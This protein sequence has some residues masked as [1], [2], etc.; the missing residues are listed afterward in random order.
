[1][2]KYNDIIFFL[3]K[4]EEDR[5][6]KGIELI[7]SENYVSNNVIKSIGSILTNKYAEGYPNK[8]YYGGC[9][10]IDKIEEKTIKRAKKL[11]KASFA[12]VQPH[13]GSQANQAVYLACL[14]PGDKILGFNLSHGGHLS[15]GSKVNFSGII[16]NSIF[17]GVKKS[18]NLIDYDQVIDIAKKEKPKLII[19]GAS[20]YSRD[21]DYKIFRQAADLNGSILLADISHTAGLIAKN[22]L[23]N[24][25]PYCH[26]I[27]TTTHKTLRGPRGGLILVGEDFFIKK[28]KIS[29]L[30]NKAVFP[31]IQGGPFENIIA[32]KA[33]AFKEAL[34]KKYEKYAKNIIINSKEL[35]KH[36]KKKG[37]NIIS[38]GTDNHCFILNLKNKKISGK[39]AEELLEKYNITCNKNLIPYDN[40]SPFITSGIRIGTPAITTRGLKKKNMKQ[41]VNWIDIILE[42]RNNINICNKIKKEIKNF[43]YSYPLFKE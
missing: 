23:N 38:N 1:M 14:N 29:F 36:F 27:T 13:S 17:Y 33:I 8:R 24:P 6:K 41:I 37:Y 12:N 9:N 19:C 28:K 16:Y 39:E 35:S 40:K 10:L 3:I 18:N 34:N 7:A 43:M 20:S 11:F 5:Q 42:N 25:F 31:G 2:K 4:K 26:I 22:L 15:H 30:I 32:G 21:I